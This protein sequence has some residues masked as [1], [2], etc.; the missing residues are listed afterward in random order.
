MFPVELKQMGARNL[1]IVWDDGHNSLY[2]VRKIRLECKCALCVDEW[3]REK[4]L[5]DETV[6][7]DVRPKSITPVGRYALRF[8]WSDGHA[9]GIYTFESL[10]AL[11]E[12][13]A[14]RK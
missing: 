5:K 2:K 3:S 10:R 7:E 6:P 9:T 4:L 12:C 11:C 1:G 13:P 14:C 8:D